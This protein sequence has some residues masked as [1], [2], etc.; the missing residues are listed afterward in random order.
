MRWPVALPPRLPNSRQPDQQAVVKL[1]VD[2]HNAA[3]RDAC[4][5]LSVS[6][7]DPA[8]ELPGAALQYGTVP[9]GLHADPATRLRAAE[10]AARHARPP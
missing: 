3:V 1:R 9:D 6:F 2:R 4:R 8:A 5:G 7:F 10:I